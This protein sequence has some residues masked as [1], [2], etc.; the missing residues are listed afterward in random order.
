MFS[1]P[2]SLGFYSHRK[3]FAPKVQFFFFRVD[4]ISKAAWNTDT[5]VRCRHQRS[6]SVCDVQ[7]FFDS[8]NKLLVTFSHGVNKRA[9]YESCHRNHGSLTSTASAKNFHNQWPAIKRQN[10]CQI[11]RIS[12]QMGWVGGG[13]DQFGSVK[14]PI[15]H[16]F[17]LVRP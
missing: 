16:D 5:L 6:H 14:S 10:F 1:S 2:L 4:P 7:L 13:G 8:L 15:E 11:M 12:L 17:C 9:G 3:E